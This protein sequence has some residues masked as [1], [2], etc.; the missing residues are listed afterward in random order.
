MRQ[1]VVD[2]RVGEWVSREVGK[3]WHSALGYALGWV[4]EEGKL[5]G[6]VTFTNYDGT[7]VWLDAAG[8]P[9][10][11]WLDRRGLF[12]IL[13][14]CFEQMECKQA[15]ALVP[16]SNTKSRKLMKQIGFDIEAKLAEAAPAGGDMLI[17][18]MFKED[19]PWLNRATPARAENTN[20]EVPCGK[21]IEA[22]STDAA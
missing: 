6:G 15:S 21:E 5:L 16:E 10:S 13:Q 12:L 19:C 7:T 20:N 17:Y 9:K 3:L 18:T 1:P 2:D 8:V 11:R 14:Y 22:E 4:D